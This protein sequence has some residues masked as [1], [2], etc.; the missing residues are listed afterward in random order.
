MQAGGGATK[1][2]LFCH[3]HEVFQLT[4]FHDASFW[5]VRDQPTA[6]TLAQSAWDQH[7]WPLQDIKHNARLSCQP[8]NS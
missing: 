1:V 6:N 3:S 4:K 2:Q 7:D 5:S 8:G